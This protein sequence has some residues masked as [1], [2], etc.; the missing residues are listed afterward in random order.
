MAVALAVVA[1]AGAACGS[2]QEPA[3]TVA[4]MA[5]QAGS[6][7]AAP[8]GGSQADP[9]AFAKCVRENGV[10]NFKDP[11]PGVGMGDGIDLNSPAFKKAAEACKEFMP[12]PPPQNNPGETWSTSDKLKYATCMRD[13]GVP[14]FPDPD[15]DG[16]FKLNDDPNTPQFK[17]AEEA[18]EQYQP[19][20]IRNMAPSKTGGG[21]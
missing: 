8:Q 10:P 18:C 17:K 21:S 12:A 7:S 5:P 6:A 2:G 1:L 4:S 19:Q 16:G 9:V 15:A 11:E 3:R 20:S 13:N 14:S